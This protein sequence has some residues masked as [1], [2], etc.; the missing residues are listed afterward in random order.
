MHNTVIEI[1]SQQFIQNIQTIRDHVNHNNKRIKFCLPIKANA[2]GHGLV[3]I[4]KIAQEY[5][6]Y[7]GVA[8]LDE[9]VIL[10]QHGIIKPI[11]V[12]GSFAEG[13][14]EALINN[15]LE[16]T[17]SSLYKAQYV[18][19]YC[20]STGKVCNVH[21]KV[22]T[23]MNRI[24]VRVENARYLIDYVLQH[25]CL[26]L[27]GAYSHLAS[28]DCADD[29]FTKEQITKFAQVVLYIKK[30]KPETICHLA[31]SG[32]VCYYPDSYFDMVRPG[33][34]SYGYSPNKLLLNDGLS[35]TASCFEL[36]SIVSYFKVVA[37][38]QGISYN[39]KYTT[40]QETRVVTIPIGYGDG[41]RRCLSNIGEVLIRGHMYKVSGTICMDMLMVDIGSNEA[42]VGDEVVLIGK[43][44][45][46]NITLESVVNKC[47]TITYE[48]L[49]S[50]NDRIPRVYL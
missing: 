4:A 35:Y 27:V 14:V 22:D 19:E 30:H 43:Q 47:S 34:M 28:S 31:N 18:A 29:G 49:C 6:D 1:N 21:I 7:F 41:Y 3:G 20:E 10:R 37:A 8:C 5:V 2:Y 50:F 46:Q 42:Y 15:S 16:V 17:V 12:F 48:I 9:G 36:K 13:Q 33:I 23:G 39:H 44:G 40:T 11:L 26:N 45:T 38:N 25:K 24:G 32:G